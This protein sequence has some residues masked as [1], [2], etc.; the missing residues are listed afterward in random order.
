MFFARTAYFG[1]SP[2]A[3]YALLALAAF[4]WGLYGPVSR[5]FLSLGLESQEI[6]FLRCLVGCVCFGLHAAQR[7]TCRMAPGDLLK[8]LLFGFIG[9]GMLNISYQLAVRETGAALSA[10]LL[11]TAPAWVALMSAVLFRHKLTWLCLVAMATAM[12][13]VVL[14]TFAGSTGNT[15]SLF[16]I[17]CGLA[18]AFFYALHFPWNY[19]W[20]GRYSPILIYFYAMLGGALLL[21]PFAGLTAKPVLVWLQ[22]LAGLVFVTYVPY[23]CYGLGMRNVTPTPA[24]IIVNLEPVVACLVATLWL[25]ESF[26]PGG[27][28][29]TG[30]VIGA[31]FLLVAGSE[32]TGLKTK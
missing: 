32:K 8:T 30:L 2:Q 31:V 4:F 10:I 21:L 18:S 17:V 5:Y 28:L 20:R 27:W 16:G 29:G 1:A 24:A 7:G 26:T 6:A 13:G 9:L 15:L 11:Y 19:H 25:N 12:L 22:V 23:L 14:V 3:G